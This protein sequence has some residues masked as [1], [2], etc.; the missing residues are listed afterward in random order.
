MKCS[1]S[2]KKCDECKKRKASPLFEETPKHIFRAE[3]GAEA[4]RATR[5]EREKERAREEG[6]IFTFE[7]QHMKGSE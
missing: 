2:E 4:R 7:A 5:A 1:E 3:E 6:G